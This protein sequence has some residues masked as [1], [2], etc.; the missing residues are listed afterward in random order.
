MRSHALFA[1]A[2]VTLAQAQAP[3][4]FDPAL[5]AKGP[6][7]DIPVVGFGTWSL[8][9]G[10]NGTAAVKS[11]LEVGFRHLD[12]ATAYTNQDAVGKGIAAA[13]AANKDLKREDIWVTSKLWSTRH[14]DKIP[15]GMDLNLQQ[16]NLTYVD[17]SLMHFPVGTTGPKPEYDYVKVRTGRSLWR[18]LC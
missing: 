18:E 7:A 13:L 12:G 15:S 2:L 8:V 4:G 10:A 11:A 5:T 1:P 6:L 3:T 9:N 17:L 16:L 14:G